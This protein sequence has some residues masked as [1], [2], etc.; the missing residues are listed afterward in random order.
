M[1][2][3]NNFKSAILTFVRHPKV[4]FNRTDDNFN[5]MTN[6][7]KKNFLKLLGVANYIEYK[8]NK[9]SSLDAKSFIEKFL[10]QQLHIK[11]IVVGKD[12]RFGKDRSRR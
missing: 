3:S 4:Y 7:D 1:L 12:F 6:D 5:I 11:K 9:R 2:K 8:F 10:V